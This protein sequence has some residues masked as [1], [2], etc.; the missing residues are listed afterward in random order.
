MKEVLILFRG[1]KFI[2]KLNAKPITTAD[3]VEFNVKSPSDEI[4]CRSCIVSV[5]ANNLDIDQTKTVYVNKNTEMV[6]DKYNEVEVST[7]PSWKVPF[8]DQ[9]GVVNT[10]TTATDNLKK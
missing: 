1:Q 2:I 6:V 8:R 7:L 3:R 5:V 9:Y 4:T 10:D